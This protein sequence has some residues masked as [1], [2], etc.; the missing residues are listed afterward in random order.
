[1]AT[2][3]A[4]LDVR[5]IAYDR[6]R[7]DLLKKELEKIGSDLPLVEWGQGYR[8]MAPA[9]DALEAELLNGRVA[10]GMHPVL[11]M[12]AGNAVVTKDRPAPASSTRAAPRAASTACR[13]SPWRWVLHRVPKKS[14]TSMQMAPSLLF[15]PASG[16]AQAD[17]LDADYS[18][19]AAFMKNP[20]CQRQGCRDIQ[21]GDNFPCAAGTFLKENH[22]RP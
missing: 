13:H 8:D 20:E 10:H 21:P 5:A 19:R 15:N 14:G 22:A 2:L 1:M 18:G 3:L 16:A 11:T 4:G 6:W 9:L 17:W 12:C 7:I